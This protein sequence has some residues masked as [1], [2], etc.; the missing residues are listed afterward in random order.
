MHV[1]KTRWCNKKPADLWV[2]KINGDSWRYVANLD[3]SGRIHSPGDLS[4]Y[5]F[6]KPQARAREALKCILYP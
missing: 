2:P 4:R 1:V 6:V 3:F 5:G